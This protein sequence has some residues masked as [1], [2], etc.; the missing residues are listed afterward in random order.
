MYCYE[1]PQTGDKT[2]ARIFFSIST[3]K[4]PAPALNQSSQSVVQRMPITGDSEELSDSL[5]LKTESLAE[6]GMDDIRIHYSTSKPVRKINS[7][8]VHDHS[9]LKRELMDMEDKGNNFSGTA[10]L[11]AKS[12]IGQPCIQCLGP[13]DLYTVVHSDECKTMMKTIESTPK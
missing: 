8:H 12:A 2:R 6:Y 10:Q 13:K 7:L 3:K 11:S 9:P 4:A 5:Q 1:R